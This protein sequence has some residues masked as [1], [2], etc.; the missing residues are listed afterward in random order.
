MILSRDSRPGWEVIFRPA[1]GVHPEPGENAWLVGIGG[2][3]GRIF[4]PL[5]PQDAGGEGATFQDLIL[6]FIE[7]V[8]LRIALLTQDLQKIQDLRCVA[9]DQQRDLARVRWRCQ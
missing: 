5:L 9:L 1:C 7:I 6:G 3:E 8:R 2:E 4:Q